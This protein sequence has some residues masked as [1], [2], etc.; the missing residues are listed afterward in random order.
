M[1]AAYVITAGHNINT[2]RSRASRARATKH[3]NVDFYN[4]IR[5]KSTQTQPFSICVMQLSGSCSFFLN[6]RTA[7]LL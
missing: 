3:R 7:I 5:E 4:N 2:L 1:C 6:V